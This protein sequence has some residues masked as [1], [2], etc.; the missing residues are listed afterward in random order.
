MQGELE[1]IFK[2]QNG[3]RKAFEEL[4]LLYRKNVCGL[5]YRMTGNMEAAED[6]TQEVFVRVYQALA[7]FSPSRDGAF[8]SWVLTI[9][10]RICIDRFRRTRRHPEEISW[11]QQPELLAGGDDVSDLVL[12]ENLMAQIREALLELPENYRLALTLKYLEDLEY[13]EIAGIME[14]PVGTVGTLIHRGLK[15]LRTH[16]IGKGIADEEIAAQ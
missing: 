11:D 2:A 8:K 9:T 5:A 13:R 10:S 6:I 7:G 14:I 4:V 15:M 1:L 12:R 16:L 3:N